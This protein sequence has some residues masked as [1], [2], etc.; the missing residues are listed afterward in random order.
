MI[1]LPQ[2][3]QNDIQGKDTY[4]VP[5]VVINDSI[6]LS[7]GKVTLGNQY[8]DPLIKSLGNIKESIDIFEKKF[9]VSSVSMDFFN[10]EYN[11]KRLLDRF[12]ED[13]IINA[14]VDVYYKSQSALSLNDCIK[15]YTGYV[16]EIVERSDFVGLEIE[17]R[18]EQ[19]LGK[20]VPYNFTK[21]ADLPEEQRNK[22]IPIVY[23]QVDRCP[24]VYLDNDNLDNANTYKL[25][26]DDFDIVNIDDLKVFTGE[27]YLSAPQESF[28][29][30]QI[31]DGIFGEA[32]DLQSA[33]LQDQWVIQNNSFII[34]KSIVAS[35]D[36]NISNSDDVSNL[37]SALPAYNYIEVLQTYKPRFIGGIYRLYQV[38]VGDANFDIFE[39]QLSPSADSEGNF[40]KSAD[41]P[42][43]VKVNDYSEDLDNPE[44]Q[45]QMTAYSDINDYNSNTDYADFAQVALRGYNGYYFEA[46]NFC[47]SSDVLKEHNGAGIFSLSWINYDF[48]IKYNG[49]YKGEDTFIT[50]VFFFNFGGGSTEG[51]CRALFSFS[52]SGG[53]H[54]FPV[55][56]VAEG[57]IAEN[58]A[59]YEAED[60][61][62]NGKNDGTDSFDSVNFTFSRPAKT[63][64][65]EN[66]NFSI[67]TDPAFAS[68]FVTDDFGA[69]YVDFVG[70]NDLTLTKN[71]IL[72]NFN[73]F[74]LYANVIGRVDN[75]SLRYTSTSEL[76]T[77]SGM[78][79]GFQ[80]P[81]EQFQT[82]PAGQARPTRPVSTAKASIRDK[83]KIRSR[84]GGSGTGGGGY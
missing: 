5:L 31:D 53:Q 63:K 23:G 4:L 67:S 13:E 82:A 71:A 45:H 78:Q 80:Q 21:T 83:R 19:V 49:I 61:E 34:Q 30:N 62:F 18:T 50:P 1:E 46:D 7:T 68:S 52:A 57:S 65:I 66:S 77:L 32:L 64:N 14:S 73:D 8:Y 37:Q 51:E 81:K 41:F 47:N 33:V 39:H 27:A 9:K 75:Q 55:L 70:F 42:F 56:E 76:Q 29:K 25:S 35:E 84:G 2:R 72:Q 43:Y 3:F 48:H 59:V 28:L 69:G 79:E 22:P 12:F 44:I 58:S 11:N 20:K 16:K 10:Y 17:D 36:S 74:N 60:I 6:Y 24:L 40:S 54:S 38:D 15:V 26:A